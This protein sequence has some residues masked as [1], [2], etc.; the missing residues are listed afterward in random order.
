MLG[1]AYWGRGYATEGARRVLDHAFL[2]VGHEH[3]ISL[4][5]PDNTASIRVA[6]RIGE[7]FEGHTILS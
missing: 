6:E 7:R 4:I 1:K 5:Y 3:L 2:D